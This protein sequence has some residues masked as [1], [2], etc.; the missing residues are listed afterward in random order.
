M[1]GGLAA[2]AHGSSVAT[3]D[4]DVCGSFSTENITRLEHALR[5]YQPWHR[6]SQI[7]KKFDAEDISKNTYRNI[8]LSTDLGQL[9]FLSEVRGLGSLD[10]I[11]KN[12]QVIDM[13]LGEVVVPVLSLD[14]I[15]LAK[16]A[17]GRPRDLENVKI[18]KAI[19]DR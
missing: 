8:Y 13:N 6:M 4:I 14:A 1:I 16:E 5:P 11:T 12:R 18:L 15:I 9:D 3:Q 7:K 19:R 10:E 17:M 2:S